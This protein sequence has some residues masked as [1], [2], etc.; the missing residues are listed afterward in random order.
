MRE[1]AIDRAYRLD[2]PEAKDVAFWAFRAATSHADQAADP[3]RHARWIQR[4]LNDA[5]NRFEPVE[6]QGAPE[7]KPS[8]LISLEQAR[9]QT[10][11]ARVSLVQQTKR[12]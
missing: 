10:Q 12:S 6:Q 5:I 1:N 11:A 2:S 3:G 7:E 8:A 9:A 4:K